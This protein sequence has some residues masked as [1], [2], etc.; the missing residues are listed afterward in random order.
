MKSCSLPNTCLSISC[1]VSHLRSSWLDLPPFPHCHRE[2]DGAESRGSRTSLGRK[3]FK[4]AGTPTRNLGSQV[5]NVTHRSGASVTFIG[6]VFNPDSGD[7]PWL[8][9]LDPASKH[10]AIETRAHLQEHL[11]FPFV[12]A[13]ATS[14]AQP[15]DRAIFGTWKY[16]V[17][18]HGQ[19]S[20]GCFAVGHGWSVELLRAAPEGSMC[21][22]DTGYVRGGVCARRELRTKAWR[23]PGV[24]QR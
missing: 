12:A 15:P 3:N 24:E 10:R 8:L 16:V 20:T 9:L 5:S 14:F 21:D 4:C 7:T 19:S 2:K 13:G 18:K 11:K 22:V 1:T 23:P 6:G 17:S